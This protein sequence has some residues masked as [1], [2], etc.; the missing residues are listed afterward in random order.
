METWW[1][2]ALILPLLVAVV[3]GLALAWFERQRR[4]AAVA[5]ALEQEVNALLQEARDDLEAWGG[6]PKDYYWLQSGRVLRNAPTQIRAEHAVFKAL[7]PDLPLLGAW[8]TTRIL[9][10]YNHLRFCEGLA[11]SLSAHLNWFRDRGEALTP[12]DTRVLESRRQRLRA[13][14]SSLVEPYRRCDRVSLCQLVEAYQAPSPRPVLEALSEGA[15]GKA[16]RAGTPPAA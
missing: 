1:G 12:D 3:G 16:S 2:D 5:A 4:R 9:A 7:L 13:A 15:P 6:D 10:F 11:E 14:Y 8:H